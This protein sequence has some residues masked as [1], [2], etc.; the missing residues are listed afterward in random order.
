MLAVTRKPKGS[1]LG[2]PVLHL[3]QQADNEPLSD[4]FACF[5][6][7]WYWSW[8]KAAF[9]MCIWSNW[10]NLQ[11]AARRMGL[12]WQKSLPNHRLAIIPLF[13][14]EE[15]NPRVKLCTL[16]KNFGPEHFNSFKSD[17]CLY[18][19]IYIFTPVCFASMVDRD[20]PPY[21]FSNF[22][23]RFF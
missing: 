22:Y 21:G 11:S 1:S 18:I 8:T 20:T 3:K 14:M 17:I 2:S 10:S 6:H 5:A 19:F 15:K 9:A 4:L 7:L 16:F 12:C 13:G 23:V